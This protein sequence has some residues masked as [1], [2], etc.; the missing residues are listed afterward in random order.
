MERRVISL[1]HINMYVR[2]QQR[3]Q[4]TLTKERNPLSALLLI[5]YD[6]IKCSKRQ[7]DD[8]DDVTNL[9]KVS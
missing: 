5:T 2:F 4:Q 3:F 1:H 8:G 7:V 6:V 9:H